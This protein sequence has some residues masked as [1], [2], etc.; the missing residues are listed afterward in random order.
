LFS[1]PEKTNRQW[2]TETCDNIIFDE[3]KLSSHM[4]T[5]HMPNNYERNLKKAYKT[6]NEEFTKRSDITLPVP[7]T[8][9]HN[10][11]NPDRDISLL[12]NIVQMATVIPSDIAV[13]AAHMK[14]GEQGKDGQNDSLLGDVVHVPDNSVSL[15]GDVVQTT[16]VLPS[17][18]GVAAVQKRE[19]SVEEFVEKDKK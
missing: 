1:P 9:E 19:G 12:G 3:I 7:D 10:I 14:D 5:D 17:D 6:H 2:Y 8:S 4:Y 16:T 15:L 18:L 11:T 13:V